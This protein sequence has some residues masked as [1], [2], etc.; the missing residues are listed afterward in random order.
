M[1]TN[2]DTRILE[3]L[4][5]KVCHDL[6]SPIG[7]VNNGIEFLEEMGPEAGEEATSLIAFSAQQ[8][9]SKLQVYR[10]AYGAGGADTSIKPED[11]HKM[12]AGMIEPE[13]KVKQE[14][15]P[16]GD[17]GHGDERPEAFCKMLACGF[18]LALECMPKGGIFKIE[19]GNGQTI[20][21]ATG[22]DAAPKDFMSKALALEIPL[23][24]LETKH[25]HAYVTGLLAQNY[26]FQVSIEQNET[27][28]VIINLVNPS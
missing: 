10:M 14:W 23:D 24:A 27:N 25:V 7:A 8:A 15:D 6:I 12:F 13:G 22:D 3:L 9:S 16:Y 28:S 17:L 21:T 11:A 5:S 19:G 18:I 20:I 4:A 1:S 2:F 26:N